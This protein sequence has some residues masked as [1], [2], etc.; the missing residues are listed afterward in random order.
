[1]FL[2]SVSVYLWDFFETVKVIVIIIKKP[3]KQPKPYQQ[4][5]SPSCINFIKIY[6]VIPKIRIYLINKLKKLN[7]RKVWGKKSVSYSDSNQEQFIES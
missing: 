4:S 1:M 2:S 5:N 3:N 6:I 7:E